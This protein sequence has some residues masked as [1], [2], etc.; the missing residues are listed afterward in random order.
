M[1]ERIINIIIIVVI[2]ALCIGGTAYYFNSKDNSKNL[3]TSNKNVTISETNTIS[4]SV[5]KVY[6]ATVVVEGYKNDKLAGSGSG[7]IYKVDNKNV[8]V[9]T[10]DHVISGMNKVKVVTMDGETYDAEVLGS[11]EY[12]DIAVL[13]FTADSS[14]QAFTI[15]ETGDSSNM[16][17]GDTVFTVGTPVGTDY[18]GTVTKGIISGKNRTITVGGENGSSMTE[19]IQTDA[20]IN[21]GNSGG[22]LVNVNGEVIGVN[23]MKLA[24]TSVEGMGFAIPIELAM[25][26]V[27]KLE[28]GEAIVRPIVGVSLADLDNIY[29][30]YR[31]GINVPKDVENGAVVA[32]VEEGSVAD[33]AGLEKGDVIVEVDGTEIKNTAHFRHLLYKH[34]IGDTMKI[35]YNRDGKDKTVTVKLTEKA[36]NQ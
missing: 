18:M 15:A 27:D 9:M 29:L 32:E 31:N 3:A 11:D 6:N 8:Y 17:I 1:R 22:P 25:S 36:E 30:L 4:D 12:M 35:T 28:K 23:S 24:D 16:E 20:S 14:K 26:Q 21:P 7:F 34:D 5:D 2:A 10:N 19:V 13:K 33:K